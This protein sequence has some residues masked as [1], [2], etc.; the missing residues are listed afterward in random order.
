MLLT[1]DLLNRYALSV[2]RKPSLIRGIKGLLAL[3]QRSL[4]LGAA[5]CECFLDLLVHP[6]SRPAARVPAPHREYGANA[7]VIYPALRFARSTR[8]WHFV[9]CSKSRY[10][11]KE[12][13]CG[14]LVICRLR[15]LMFD[16]S[17]P[18]K[19]HFAFLKAH[20]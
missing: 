15:R 16:Q 10:Q 18:I 1:T 11:A 4:R 7:R 14:A 13:R 2:S 8:K 9:D 20:A 3:H 19:S 17:L 12:S 6:G 5:R